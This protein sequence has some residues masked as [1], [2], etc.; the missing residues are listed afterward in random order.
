MRLLK[1]NERRFIL[2]VLTER[3]VDPVAVGLHEAV[4]AEEMSDGGMGSLR[5]HPDADPGDG[6]RKLGR[7]LAEGEFADSDGVPVSFVVNAA[8][9]GKLFELDL[10]KVDFSPLK[11][12][13]ATE[14]PVTLK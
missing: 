7:K 5:L 6:R 1:D 8:E 3:G 9:D 4:R 11:S 14:T 12:F 2:R 13:P 10:W